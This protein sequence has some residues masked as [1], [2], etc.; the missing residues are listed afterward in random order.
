MIGN[1]VMEQLKKLDKIL[2]LRRAKAAYYFKHLSNIDGVTLPH[3]PENC[4]HTF[5]SYVVVLDASLPRDRIGDALERRGIAV[6][7]GNHAV[8]T[9]GIFKNKYGHKPG[10]FPVSLR[11][12]RA[13]L[14]LP[15]FPELTR[16]QQRYVVENLIDVIRKQG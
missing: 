15:L 1:L 8:H 11:L 16:E 12:S 3:V 5:Q 2:K 10:D 4:V 14:A 7:Q 6:R 13:T 9:L